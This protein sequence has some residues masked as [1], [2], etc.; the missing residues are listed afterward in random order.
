M[1]CWLSVCMYVVLKSHQKQLYNDS[2][3]IWYA[4]YYINRCEG[5][6]F[7]F[8]GSIQIHIEN[9]DFLKDGLSIFLKWV[10]VV[11]V[12]RV[13][14]KQSSGT[15]DKRQKVFF[16]VVV[17]GTHKKQLSLK[18][19]IWFKLGKIVSNNFNKIILILLNNLS[20]KL[21]M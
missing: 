17:E 16:F 4:E 7:W 6:V 10:Y 8:I 5:Y 3:L 18:I 15:W 9:W 14:P 13:C 2:D 20:N 19:K 11:H 12:W 1:S 21:Y